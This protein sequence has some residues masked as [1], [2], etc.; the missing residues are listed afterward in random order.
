MSIPITKPTIQLT[1]Q[2]GNAMAIIA[3]CRRAARDDG[4]TPDEIAEWVELAMSGDYN[5]VLMMAMEHFDVE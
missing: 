3:R 2:D 1:G 5:N 4:W